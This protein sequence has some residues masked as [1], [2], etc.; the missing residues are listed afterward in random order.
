MALRTLKDFE[1]TLNK[2]EYSDNLKE[3]FEFAKGAFISLRQEAIKWVK[4]GRIINR[5][6]WRCFFNI[7][8]E[9]LASSKKEV[10]DG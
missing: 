1:E 10:K 5:T 2:M 6:V 4:D 8:D 9:E 3:H 7:T